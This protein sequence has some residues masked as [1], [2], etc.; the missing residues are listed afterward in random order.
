M[1]D[2]EDEESDKSNSVVNDEDDEETGEV[3]SLS[4]GSMHCQL[5]ILRVV[6]VLHVQWF[7]SNSKIILL[8]FMIY[9]HHL[10]FMLLN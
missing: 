2:D 7:S 10:I 9:N 6:Q 8:I 3:I 4:Y 5:H 1:V